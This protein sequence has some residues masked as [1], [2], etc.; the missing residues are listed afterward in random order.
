MRALID[1]V[2]V[3]QAPPIRQEVEL[4]A[5]AVVGQPDVLPGVDA[6]D[7]NQI[8]AAGVLLALLVAELGAGA[9]QRGAVV[10]VVLGVK[11]AADRVARLVGQAANTVHV[12]V[13][14]APV[15]ARVGASREVGRQEAVLARVALQ[16]RV[17]LLDEPDEARAEHGVGG[18]DHLA[19]QGIDAA[20]GQL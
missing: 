3:N 13:L 10:V 16:E 5:T 18:Q 15:G 11:V 20:K 4:A 12:H 17:G 9:V 6:Q 14:A 2:P 7:G 8:R 1:A 19:L